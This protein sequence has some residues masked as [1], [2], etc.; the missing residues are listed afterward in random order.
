MSDRVSV[1]SLPDE[2]LVEELPLPRSTINRLR[3]GGVLTLGDLRAMPDRELLRLRH[4]G[5]HSLAD[6]RALVP[7]PDGSD[8]R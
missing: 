3:V 7:A 4:F 2:T 6:V 1:A 8:T 5:P